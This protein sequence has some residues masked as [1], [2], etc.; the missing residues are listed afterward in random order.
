[1]EPPVDGDEVGAPVEVHVG[2]DQRVRDLGGVE[3][4]GFRQPA[5]CNLEEHLHPG[6]LRAEPAAT[7][8]R[9]SP[10]KSP[11]ARPFWRPSPVKSPT[12][13]DFGA[14]PTR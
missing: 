7:S 14:G 10:L 5:G 4:V 3:W 8:V 1:M 2:G 9:P 6:G 13:T 11:T 12:T